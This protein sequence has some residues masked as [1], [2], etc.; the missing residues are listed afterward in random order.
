MKKW[1][2]LLLALCLPFSAMAEEGKTITANGVVESDR[3]TEITAPYSGV[4][5]PFDWE[6]G[7]V[8][9]AGEALFEMDTFKVYAPAAGTVAALF[10][11][12]G[13][14]AADVQQQYGMLAAI[15]KANDLT[16]QCSVTGA[17]NES[18]NRIVHVGET[19]YVEQSNDRD[20][21]G[22]GR[23][24]AV[25]GKNYVVELT[26]GD[27]EDGDLIKVYRDDKMSTKSCIGS[28]K[29]ARAAAVAVN[30]AG[31][32]LRCAVEEGQ[33]VKKG[34]LLFEMASQDAEPWLESAVITA[35]NGG[36]LEM[37]AMSGQQTY[38]GM[39]LAR[40][41]DLSRMNVVASVDEMDLDLIA[42]GDTLTVA[43]DRYPDELFVGTVSEISRLG[44]P[45]Q[46][47]TYYDVTIALN[48]Q[49]ELLP[50]M[51]ATVWLA[52]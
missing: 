40:V 16:A 32:V 41:H 20:N 38:K 9:G 8:V 39:V 33:K 47:A 1:F 7:D 52:E 34:D 35:E 48:A 13:D 12:S 42:V 21:E 27:F 46:N 4:V 26:Q 5:L 18:E 45:K 50:G 14:L 25:D 37:A 19:V 51:N 10:A 6:A 11:E 43:F 17:Y 22:E 23:V 49:S 3:V 30:G 24:I 31:R 44:V 36:A 29:I 15:E 28:G 2:V